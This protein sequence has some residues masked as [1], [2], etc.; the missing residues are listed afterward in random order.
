MT[1]VKTITCPECRGNDSHCERCGGLGDIRAGGGYLT[2]IQTRPPDHGGGGFSLLG[3]AVG[4][5]AGLFASLFLFTF[6]TFGAG[7]WEGGPT[8]SWWEQVL[9]AVLIVL[10]AIVPIAGAW[11]LG[12]LWNSKGGGYKYVNSATSSNM[13]A[14]ANCQHLNRIPAT[15]CVQCG[16]ALNR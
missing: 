6:A 15:Y 9:G 13:T 14:C 5:V 1:A 10:A 7:E 2:P 11:S 3:G 8:R 4:F 12:S 16:H